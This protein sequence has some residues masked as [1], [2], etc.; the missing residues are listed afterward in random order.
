MPYFVVY[1]LDKVNSSALRATHRRTHRARLRAPD[2]RP[3]NVHIDGSLTDAQGQ[4]I[5]PMLVIEAARQ[6]V[7]EG[8]VDV[9][10]CRIAGPYD[11]FDILPFKW[12]FGQPEEALHG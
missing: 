3:L 5:G 11:R 10:P 9:D 12:V 2:G 4:M 1:A 6:E 7:V 8:F